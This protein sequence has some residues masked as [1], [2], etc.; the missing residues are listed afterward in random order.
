MNPHHQGRTRIY[1][2]AGR[3]FLERVLLGIVGLAILVLAFF[4]LTVALLA[5][6]LL[7]GVILARWWWLSR[8]IRAARAAQ[9]DEIIEGEYTKVEPEGPGRLTH[10]PER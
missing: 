10:P 3:S 6:A 4:F 9:A 2:F 5:G 1:T 7:A 8:K